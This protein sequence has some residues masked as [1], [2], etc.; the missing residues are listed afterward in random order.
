MTPQ[1]PPEA[2]LD[3]IAGLILLVL[4]IYAWLRPDASI[5]T[6]SFAFFTT[7][8]VML[9]FWHAVEIINITLGAKI[10]F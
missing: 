3:S 2:I 1:I 10:F 5:L 6:R 4:S 8:I 7:A 9:L